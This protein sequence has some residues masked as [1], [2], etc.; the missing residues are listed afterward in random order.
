MDY[1]LWEISFAN[2]T[3]LTASIPSLK[4]DKKEGEGEGEGSTPTSKAEL[5]DG[6]EDAADLFK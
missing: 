5:V 1:V 4:T 2:L 6:F 3:L